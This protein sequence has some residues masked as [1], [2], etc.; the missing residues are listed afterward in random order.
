MEPIDAAHSHDPARVASEACVRHQL[1]WGFIGLTV[2]VGLGV[3]LEA[4]HAFKWMGYLHVEAETRR[5]LLRLG[6]AHGTLLSLLQIGVGLTG[7]A[8]PAVLRSVRPVLY[9]LAQWLVPAGFVLGALGSRASDPGPMIALLPAGAV[10]L[11][12]ALASTAWSLRAP[13][14]DE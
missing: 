9:S 7:R 4:F 1:R 3:I 5:M 8:Y 12:V 10:C 6:H 2:F 13:A 14:R 11:L